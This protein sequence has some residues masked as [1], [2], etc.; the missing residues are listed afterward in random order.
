MKWIPISDKRPDVGE[1]VLI[2]VDTADSGDC[3]VTIA[4]MCYDLTDNE[5]W[6]QNDD[7]SFDMDEVFAWMPLP[8]PYEEDK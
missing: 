1:D 2:S 6:F 5:Y 4:Y 8:E 7:M 3:W